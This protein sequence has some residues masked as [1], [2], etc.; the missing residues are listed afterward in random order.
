MTVIDS[1]TVGYIRRRNYATSNVIVNI[2][3]I[4][5][6]AHPI[7]AKITTPL[8]TLPAAEYVVDT[9][10]TDWLD[11]KAGMYCVVTRSGV[12]TIRRGV[13]RLDNASGAL[14]LA[15]AHTGDT[16]DTSFSAYEIED[17]DDVAIYRVIV[18]RAFWNRIDPI[19]IVQYHFWDIPYDTSGTYTGENEYPA[20][21]INI[22]AHFAGTLSN[23]TAPTYSV[24]FNA[25]TTGSISFSWNSGGTLS[26]SWNVISKDYTPP[27]GFPATGTTLTKAFSPGEYLVKCTG[28]NSVTGKAS[29]SYRWVFIRD[30]S[31]YKSFSDY[32]PTIIENDESDEIGRSMTLLCHSEGMN[33][34]Y[35]NFLYTG[36]PVLVT[37]TQQYGEEGW[38]GDVQPDLYPITDNFFGYLRKVESLGQNSEGVFTF[39]LLV[40]SPSLFMSD[41]PI[42]RSTFEA[43]ENPDDWNKVYAD[44]A[45][46]HFIAWAMIRDNAPMLLAQSDYVYVNNGSVI[47]AQAPAFNF[48]QGS[49]LEAV[50]RAVRYHPMANIG[51]I[52][53]GGFYI[54]RHPFLEDPDVYRVDNV[55]TCFTWQAQD[56]IGGRDDMIVLN[57]D[58]FMASYETRGK[59]I[60][61]GTGLPIHAYAARTNLFA[62]A[63]AVRSADMDDYIGGLSHLGHYHQYLNR[64][65][66]SFTINAR[67]SHDFVEPA[68]RDYHVFDFSDISGDILSDKGISKTLATKVSR[69]WNFTP[70]GINRSLSITFEP[71]SVGVDAMLDPTSLPSPY[72]TWQ[73]KLK[74]NNDD[75]GF[76]AYLAPDNLRFNQD[77]FNNVAKGVWVDG[78]GWQGEQWI[79]TTDT[80]GDYRSGLSIRRTFSAA[81]LKSIEVKYDTPHN[82]DEVHYAVAWYKTT[83][84]K[85]NLMALYSTYGS[86]HYAAT[87]PAVTVNAVGFQIVVHSPYTVYPAKP[88]VKWI[89]L[90]G[91][92]SSPF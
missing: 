13:L 36:A 23:L 81:N 57:E 32:Y 42:A 21:Q 67:G 45:T 54:R 48:P 92:G 65:I 28:T 24:N 80:W 79:T 46:P 82:P 73:T 12:G 41:L 5:A 2:P 69:R 76:E 4:Q 20:P 31:T 68:L 51:C 1:G 43:S 25:A 52:S 66:Q 38:E 26:Y 11:G 19:A 61:S 56:I 9:T 71:E 83:G 40:V 88:I 87:F 72:G 47:T 30:G 33:V 85:V 17:N 15:G 64:P 84:G 53:S 29:T 63:H 44:L 18:P 90:G 7:T 16:G 50:R 75:Q 10:S 14:Y 86:V 49:L 37:Y 70:I 74:F 55:D 39:R 8:P 34:L 6:G 89:R 22:G 78:T 77:A 91:D 58:P 60:S 62:P 3:K 27:A 35:N 59:F